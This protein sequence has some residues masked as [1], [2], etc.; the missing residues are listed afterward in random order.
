MPPERLERPRAPLRVPKGLRRAEPPPWLAAC[1]GDQAPELRYGNAGLRYAG[2]DTGG[3]GGG[4]LEWFTPDI[5][6]ATTWAPPQGAG[7][8]FSQDGAGF[9]NVT[10]DDG[11][12]RLTPGDW[13]GTTGGRV[14]T[15]ETQDE[16]WP[17]PLVEWYAVAE[18]DVGTMP[19]ARDVQVGIGFSDAQG[20]IAQ[21][22]QCR[23]GGL[24]GGIVPAAGRIFTL[25]N[26]T[27]IFGDNEV[28]S[29][30]PQV[31]LRGY[32]RIYSSVGIDTVTLT[33]GGVDPSDFAL[34]RTRN[35]T[36]A[37]DL[38]LILWFGRT[39]NSPGPTTTFRVRPWFARFAYTWPALDFP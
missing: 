33:Q 1:G 18:I 21:L 6:D 10:I 22:N 29:A 34:A 9:F 35:I 25:E 8:V 15:W 14:F 2:S 16:N 31:R 28:T 32:D 13:T 26:T 39:A 3:G 30:Y 37:F 5:G 4:S 24:R 27:F 19:L 17:V 36:A 23:V 20:E 7:D 11:G 38:G 12:N